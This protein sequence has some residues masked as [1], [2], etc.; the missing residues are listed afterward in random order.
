MQL[1]LR[2]RNAGLSC[3]S[4]RWDACIRPVLFLSLK[5]SIS[6][7][8]LRGQ[9]FWTRND[10]GL[11]SYRMNEA[12]SSRS[13]REPVQ[14]FPDVS[15][16]LLAPDMIQ[17]VSGVRIAYSGVNTVPGHYA[18]MSQ[19]QYLNPSRFDDLFKCSDRYEPASTPYSQP[20]EGRVKNLL[21]TH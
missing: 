12:H 18:D 8:T 7:L 20:C 14:A 13:K 10:V 9:E 1:V 6:R 3:T 19:L 2:A 4:D 16:D 15:L 21:C 11:N 5:P 17:S